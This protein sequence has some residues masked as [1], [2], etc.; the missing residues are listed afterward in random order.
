VF[1]ATLEGRI[2]LIILSLSRFGIPHAANP[3]EPRAPLIPNVAA[4]FAIAAVPLRAVPA[5]RTDTHANATKTVPAIIA[6]TMCASP[7]PVDN[8]NSP[9]TH[10]IRAA[11]SGCATLGPG[12]VSHVLTIIARAPR[13][14]N[15]AREALVPRLP[16]ER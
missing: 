2:A 16:R 8:M 7:G 14:L 15:A 3:L 6:S 9:A 10:M 13:T 4:G 5:I 12:P 11:A 1:A